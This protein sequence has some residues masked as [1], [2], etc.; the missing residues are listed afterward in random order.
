MRRHRFYYPAVTEHTRVLTDRH[1]IHQ[2]RDVLRAK[3]GDELVLW[4][5]GEGADYVFEIKR[6]S[7]KQIDG[8]VSSVLENDREPRIHV[9]LYCA[10]LKRENFEL[11]LQKA[12]EVGVSAIVPLITERTVKMGLNRTRAEQIVVEAAEQS[13]RGV[14][15]ELG[16]PMT[17]GDAL[18]HAKE[19]GELRNAP[20]GIFL[21][22]YSECSSEHSLLSSVALSGRAGEPCSRPAEAAEGTSLS[23]PALVTASLFIGPEGGW[24]N[25]EVEH[26]RA[27]GCITVSLGPLIL[28]AET[29]AIVASYMAVHTLL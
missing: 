12:T 24:T 9:S 10:L 21:H 18:R 28:R 4:K 8:A 14:L 3:A 5:S 29:A 26:A 6:I 1:H 27:E 20:T 23:A 25:G 15:P 13:G 17:L 7:P 2:I 16:E 19:S 22:A 11:V